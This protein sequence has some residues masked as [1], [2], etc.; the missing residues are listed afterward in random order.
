M[1]IREMVTGLKFPEGPVAMDDGSVVLCEIAGERLTRV[2]P[3]GKTQTVAKPGGGPNGLAVGP[4]GVFY[5]CNNGGSFTYTKRQGLMI[6][7]HAPEDHAGGRIERVDIS[8]GKIEALYESCDGQRLIGPNDIV[9]DAHGGFWFTDYGRGTKSSR[10]HGALYY[11]KADGSTITQVSRVCSH[12][13]RTS[14][15]RSSGWS[16]PIT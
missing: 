16:S 1:Q 11:A 5:A 8:T 10:T 12:S 4:D 15:V 9:F 3:D 2:K 7:G 14:W 6:P 13:R